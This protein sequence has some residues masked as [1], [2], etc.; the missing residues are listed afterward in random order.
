MPSHTELR[1]SAAVFFF[2]TAFFFCWIFANLAHWHGLRAL[3]LSF[4]GALLF[5]WAS[6]RWQ[7]FLIMP[8]KT[9][10]RSTPTGNRA[11]RRAAKR[12][13]AKNRD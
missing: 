5:T 6:R 13:Y 8:S 2:L 11:T 1:L 10:F 3:G 12:R 4:L 7:Q 9:R